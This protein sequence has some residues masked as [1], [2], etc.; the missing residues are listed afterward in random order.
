MAFK[1]IMLVLFGKKPNAAF[2]EVNL[3]A[4]GDIKAEVAGAV[5]VSNFPATTD[6]SA[7]T[8]AALETISVANFPA[9]YPLPASQVTTLT[10]QTNALTDVQLRA[11][12]VP[13]SGIFFQATQPVSGTIALDAASL[14]ALETISV[15]NFPATQPVSGTVDLSASSLAALETIQVGNFPAVQP[16]SDNGGSLTVDG[17]ISIS[18]S[19]PIKRTITV[20]TIGVSDLYTPAAGKRIRLHFFGYSAGANVTGTLAQLSLV[21]YNA[22]AVFDSQFLVAAGQPYARNIQAGR[23]Y[24][25]GA[26]DGKLRVT[27]S[28]AQTVHVNYELEE[29]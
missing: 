18:E 14:A 9:D 29:I 20:S 3:N 26:V 15:A 12:A 28:V 25:E 1:Q 10:P 13:V 27:L 4:A 17:T 21:G 7:A 8:L 11:T 16:V 6:L 22:D 5:S 2:Q 19:L 23:R 24:I